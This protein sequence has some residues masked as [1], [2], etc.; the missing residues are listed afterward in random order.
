MR[1]RTDSAS[2][3]PPNPHP[4]PLQSGYELFGGVDYPNDEINGLFV[5]SAVWSDVESRPE[6]DLESDLTQTCDYAYNTSEHTWKYIAY[7]EL[8]EVVMF[9]SVTVPKVLC[10]LAVRA[11]CASWL[12]DSASCLCELP[13]LARV[14]DVLARSCYCVV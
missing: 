8:Y 2:S 4:H 12:C 3:P 5:V 10:E 9:H 7:P 6:C 14:V 11:G 1:H 13:V